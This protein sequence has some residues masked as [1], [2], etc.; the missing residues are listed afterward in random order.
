VFVYVYDSRQDLVGG[1]AEEGEDRLSVLHVGGHRDVVHP[2]QQLIVEELPPIAVYLVHHRLTEEEV[3]VAEARGHPLEVEEV[4]IL[5]VV[6][7][8]HLTWCGVM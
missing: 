3:L 1:V 6:L 8:C 7:H 2:G 4:P 5:T